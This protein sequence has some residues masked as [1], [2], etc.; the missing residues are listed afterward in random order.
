MKILKSTR[1]DT[2][3]K[4]FTGWRGVLGVVLLLGGQAGWAANPPV[5]QTYY[6]PLPENQLLKMFQDIATVATPAARA[7][8]QLSHI[9]AAARWMPA[10]KFWASLS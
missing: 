7:C 9:H 4:F 5:V 6:I 3:A 1:K 2:L 8:H 10:R